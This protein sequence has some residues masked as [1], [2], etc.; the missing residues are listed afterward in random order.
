MSLYHTGECGHSFPIGGKCSICFS[1]ERDAELSAITRERDEYAS[2]LATCKNWRNRLE[3]ERDQLREEIEHIQHENE[4]RHTS[5]EWRFM[6][7]RDS[8]RDALKIATDALEYGVNVMMADIHAQKTCWPGEVDAFEDR[9]RS[10][11][12]LLKKHLGTGN[13]VR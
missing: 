3:S 4:D 9:A 7:E 6:K 10:A 11:L 13:D 5:M 1:I 2:D 12:A 8:L